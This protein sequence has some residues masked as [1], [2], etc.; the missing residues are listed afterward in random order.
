M[1]IGWLAA[2]GLLVA[3]ALLVG[4]GDAQAW[5][6]EGRVTCSGNGL[7]LGNV[8][9]NVV[10]VADGS[11]LSATTDDDGNYWLA[12]PDASASFQATLDLTWVGGGTVLA[13][14]QPAGFSTTDADWAIT[15]DWVVESAGCG[16]LGCWLTA[17]GAKFSGTPQGYAEKG[18]QVNFG[19]N[20]YPSCD[21][22][23]GQ[24]GQWNHLDKAQKL[25]FQGNIIQVDRCGNV[26]GIPPGSTSPVTPYNF[27]EFSGTGRVKSTAGNGVDLPFVCFQARAEDRNEPGS[28]GTRDG[29]KKDRYFIRVFDCTTGATIIMLEDPAQPGPTDPAAITDGNL[30]L[31]VSSCF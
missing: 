14:G 10:N 21:V 22:N 23:G 4:M 8:V 3:V 29:A 20:V 16:R 13:P 24:G 28:S 11:L 26:D 19:G 18:P 25:H 9:V 15:L 12:L 30:Q 17:G 5:H 7:P 2:R 31:H 6:V 27:I 1:K